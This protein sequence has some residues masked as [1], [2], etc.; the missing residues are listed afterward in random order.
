MIL[1]VFNKANYEYYEPLCIHESSLSPSVHSV[2]ASQIN[3]EKEQALGCEL[4]LAFRDDSNI[5]PSLNI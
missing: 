2:L 5:R 4:N 3:K 1:V